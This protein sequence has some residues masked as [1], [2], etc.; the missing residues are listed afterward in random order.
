MSDIQEGA[1]ARNKTTGERVVY[2]GGQW[3]PVEA[4]SQPIQAGS[5]QAAASTHSVATQPSEERGPTP[6]TVDKD[7]G[8]IRALTGGEKLRY[9]FGLGARNIA[10][11]TAE[12]LGLTSPERVK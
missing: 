7:T 3:L 5:P 6:F 1:T 2:R 4:T 9:G 12:M 11:N 10:L 8:N